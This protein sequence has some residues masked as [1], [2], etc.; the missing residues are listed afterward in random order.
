MFP[1]LYLSVEGRHIEIFIKGFRTFERKTK[2]MQYVGKRRNY[3]AIDGLQLLKPVLLL[4]FRS[5][6]ALYFIISLAATSVTDPDSGSGFSRVSG[7]NS[8]FKIG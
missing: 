2:I 4:Y 1:A 3:D 5:G 7:C 8:G 6:L